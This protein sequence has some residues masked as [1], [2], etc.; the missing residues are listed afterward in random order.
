MTAPTLT[1]AGFGFDTNTANDSVSFSDGAVGTVSSATVSTLTIGFTT[2]PTATGSL[3]AVVTTDGFTNTN[4]SQQVATVIPPPPTVT[5]ISTGIADS[6]TT[7]TITGTNFLTTTSSDTVSFNLGFAGTVASATTS[8]LTVNVT[9]PPTALGTLT[10]VVTVAGTSSGSAVQVATEINGT[11]TVTSNAGSGGSFSSI[12]LPY[13]IGTIVNGGQPTGGAALSG[14]TIAFASSLSNQTI[15]LAKDLAPI[16]SLTITGQGAPGLAISGGNAGAPASN[17]GTEV[18]LFWIGGTEVITTSISNLTLENATAIFLAGPT[19][20]NIDPSSTVI[21]TSDIITGSS[22]YPYGTGGGALWNAGTMT[23][24]NDVCTSNT[25]ESTTGGTGGGLVW[26]T[27][28]GTLTLN[29]DLISNN[30]AANPGGAIANEGGTA[31]IINSTFFGNTAG[32]S[33]G[34]I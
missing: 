32:A 17:E 2:Q 29:N 7:I 18:G 22:D 14:D 25:A 21:F 1:I 26:N 19:F 27:T 9:S 4:G 20:D 28:G 15:T 12:T 23:L 34:A 16:V 30:I 24:N 5:A 6:S 31:T 33:G 10:A 13:L 3:S 11:W 8:T